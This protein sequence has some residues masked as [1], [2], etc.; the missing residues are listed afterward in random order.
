MEGEFSFKGYV[1]TYKDPHTYTLLIT[2]LWLAVVR[3][4][5]TVMTAVFLAWAITR[6]NIPFRRF[7][8]WSI[9]L[10]FF[11]PLLPRILAWILM[12]SPKTGLFNQF[13]RMI[14]PIGQ[15]GIDIFSYGGI[16]F[17]GVLLWSPILF[18]LLVPAFRAMDAS[19]EESARMSGASLWTTIWRIDVPLMAPALVAAA[20]L[21]F[22]KM[23]ESFVIEAM[24]GIRANIYVLTTKIY[25]Y[26][27][28]RQ[29]PEYPQAM[30]LAVSLLLITLIAVFLQ[31][32][33]LGRREFT[34]VTGRGYRVHPTD[35]G[36]WKYMVFSLVLVFVLLNLFLPLAVLIW[37][38][39]MKFAGI[40]VSDMYTFSHYQ[41]AFSS[42]EL[43]TSIWNSIIMATTSAT[44]GMILCSLIGY[45]V[46]K[47]DFRIRGVIDLIAWIPWAIPGI[48]M[49]LGFLWTYILLPLPFGI[50]LYGSLTL[51]VLV[52][53]TLSFPIGTRTMTSTIIQLSNELEESSRVHGASWTQTF[54]RIIL[55][56][57]SPGF[58]AGWLLVFALAVKN[59]DT[60][61]LLYSPK[62][63]VMSTVIFNW[64]EL[65]L[66]EEAIVLGLIQ[67]ALIA[68][69]YLGFD[70]LVKRFVPSTGTSLT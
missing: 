25:D 53:I 54:T 24:L 11:M 43:L 56:L 46:V 1:D 62:A 39:L 27:A 57:V 69:A 44:I 63:I 18:I 61:I 20:A 45:I 59:L 30:A 3:T 58:A 70:F 26:V 42:P 67:A 15:G 38:S 37:G 47:T 10:I 22:V 2:T 40:F 29:P 36:G 35:L 65:G 21:A 12:L 34:T 31:W 68:M 48:V 16:I 50:S 60:V 14:L 51:M 23:M 5:L 4:M 8:E 28:H 64:W 17:V 13:L 9:L 33:L 19:L 7:F 41:N 32:K 49:A 55:P 66:F 6:T 52:F